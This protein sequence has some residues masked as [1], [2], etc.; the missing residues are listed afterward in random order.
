MTDDYT[1]SYPRPEG[2]TG[3]ATGTST[4]DAAKEQAGNLKEKATDAGGHLLG[5]AKGEAAAVTQEARRQL[6]DL[7]SQARTEVAG[8]AGTQQ[9]RL[10]GGLTSVGG[11][12]SQMASTT[13]EQNLATDIVREVGDRVDSLGRWLESHGPDEVLDEVRSFARRRPGTFLLVAAGA[14]MALGRL[15]RGL[16]D[17]P[18]TTR[19]NT[20]PARVATTEQLPVQTPVYSGVVE[21]SPRF[22]DDLATPVP[23]TPVTPTTPATTTW[24]QP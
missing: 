10:A 20:I 2:G 19:Q 6:G 17:A 3:T 5:E 7:W 15:T 11:Q 9:S 21:D 24:N 13:S 1:S 22:T 12:L 8:Q 16:K 18:P 4:A 23:S 14:G